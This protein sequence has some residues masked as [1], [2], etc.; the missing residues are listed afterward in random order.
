MSQLN[1]HQ[2]RLAQ[3]GAGNIA[4]Q[5][6]LD[7]S[8]A[9][10]RSWRQLLLLGAR[11]RTAELVLRFRMGAEVIQ[12]LTG[13]QRDAPTLRA[14]NH[15]SGLVGAGAAAPVLGPPLLALAAAEAPLLAF[16]TRV[17]ARRVALWAATQPAAAL[18]LSE[19]LVGFGL[20]VGESGWESFWAQLQDPQGRWFIVAQVLMDYMHVKGSTGSHDAPATG[21][22]RAATPGG[23][24]DLD[25]ARQR[26]SHTR[27]A[28]QQVHDAAT[29]TEPRG[30]GAARD[31]KA[32]PSADFGPRSVIA[33]PTQAPPGAGSRRSASG[34]PNPA[35]PF[36][37]VQQQ[38]SDWCGAACGE[39]AARRVG[40]E[41]D[42]SV[43]AATSHFEQPMIV[44]GAV[45]RAGRFKTEGL[46]AALAEQAQAPGRIWVGGQIPQDLS[47]PA[48][49]T[50]HL[51]G[52]ISSTKASVI[53]RVSGGNH[54][55]VVDE[56]MADGRIVIRDPG[57]NASVIVTAE[58]LSARRPTGDAVFSFPEKK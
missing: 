45:V 35:N 23:E 56:V 26:L 38:E 54:W 4:G 1:D 18:A 8:E 5:A 11:V 21:P 34:E 29:S 41:V 44:D 47:T 42:Q 37:H 50:T 27:A 48:G 57:A 39:M 55:I 16:A 7:A 20:Q 9:A 58:Q 31:A 52:Y 36:G 53:L 32:G 13:E 14:F 15:V 2:G 40:V 24:P 6:A 49:L 30:A 46:T 28:L 3:F 12:F 10:I 17:A 22:R 51:R 43:L 19:V 25:G 33:E